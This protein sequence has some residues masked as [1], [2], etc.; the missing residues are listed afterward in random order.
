[1]DTVR[2]ALTGMRIAGQ[3]QVSQDRG[4]LE[5]VVVDVM[6]RETGKVATSF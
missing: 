2:G 5:G 1:M 3:L 4:W 6:D